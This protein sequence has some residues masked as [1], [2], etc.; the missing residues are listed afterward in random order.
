MYSRTHPYIARMKERTL[1]TGPTSTK[2]TYHI[3]LDI[4][5]SNLPFKVGDSIGVLPTNDPHIVDRIIHKLSATGHE[6]ILDARTHT[7]TTFREYLLHKANISKVNSALLKLLNLEKSTETLLELLEKHTDP[8]S[9][10]EL[11][12]PLMPL[13]P[14]FYSIASSPKVFPNE[15]HLTVAFFQY[16]AN[17][18][19]HTGVGSHFLCHEAQV[20][21]TPIPIYV[22][23]SNHFTLPDPAAPIILIGPGTGIAP[24]RAF[25]QERLAT[26][27]PGLN[28]VFF[29]ER[30]RATD[31]YYSHFWLELEKQGRI[32]LDLAF[33]RDQAE[34]VYVQHKMLEQKKSF[35]NWIQQ[36]SYIYVCGDAEEMAKDV[37]AALQQIAREEGSMSEEDARKFIKTLRTEKRYLLDVY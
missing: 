21:S 23:P 11:C 9:P 25:L 6:E 7:T 24:F 35:W 4:E 20:E 22:Q 26:Q 5:G 12:K 14:R 1:L 33:S 18:H 2:K 34:K 30:N 10:S 19:V 13:M 8:L 31:F 32:R 29:G 3:V 16:H 15:I 28:W 27:A 17:G 37:D 36:G